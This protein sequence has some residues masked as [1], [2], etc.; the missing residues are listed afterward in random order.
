MRKLLHELLSPHAA[1]RPDGISICWKDEMIPYGELDRVTN[2]LA[3]TLRTHGCQF[4]DRVAVLIPSSA[5][6][7]F[8]ILGVLKAGCI[9]VPI[10]VTTPAACVADLLNDCRPAMILAGRFARTLLDQLFIHDFAPFFVGTLEALPIEGEYFATE[11]SGLNILQAS[12]EAV[13]CGATSRAP[14]LLFCRGGD[15]ACDVSDCASQPVFE[16]LVSAPQRPTV[17]THAEV[18]AFLAARQEFSLT[19]FDR[20]AA[21]PLHSPLAVAETFAAL[22]AGAELHVVPQEILG[23]PRQLATFVRAHEITE[24]LTNHGSLAEWI[25]SDEIL[26]GDLPSLKH[27]LWSGQALPADALRDLMQRLPLTR[28]ARIVAGTDAKFGGQFSTVTSLPEFEP[29]LMAERLP[30]A[31]RA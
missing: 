21:L 31:L 6:A 26:D 20:A 12:P 8:A 18:L 1:A 15:L 23:R 4:G 3:H 2:Q 24:W 9:A 13:V 5:N 25:Q 14:A 7:L 16:A 10:D 28:F 22:A 11:F 29:V 19:E 30:A 27:L 17:V